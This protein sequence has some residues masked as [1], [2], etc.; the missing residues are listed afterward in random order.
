[1]KLGKDSFGK[2]SLQAFNIKEQPMHLS[3]MN[4]VYTWWDTTL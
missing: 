1:M 4:Q 3:Y 2:N